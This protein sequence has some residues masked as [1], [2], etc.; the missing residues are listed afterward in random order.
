MLRINIDDLDL[1]DNPIASGKHTGAF[2]E[3]GFWAHRIL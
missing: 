2:V 1:V 3:V